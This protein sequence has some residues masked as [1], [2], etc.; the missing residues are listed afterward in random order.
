MAQAQFLSA[1]FL[2]FFQIVLA[3]IQAYDFISAHDLLLHTVNTIV[4]RGI[5]CES[6]NSEKQSDLIFYHWYD[7]SVIHFKQLR[8]CVMS[9]DANMIAS[10]ASIIGVVFAYFSFMKD[11][12][13][14]AEEFGKLQQKVLQ[15]EEQAR[16]NEHR[17]QTIENKLDNIQQTL[18]RVETSVQN[19][20]QHPN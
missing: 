19:L 14:S 4:I 12:L 15:L 3:C 17:F 13:R 7:C 18:T 11:K 1:L 16:S 5:C 8:G 6:E 20:L 2:L 9:M 10:M